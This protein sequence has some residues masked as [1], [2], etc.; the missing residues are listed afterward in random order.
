MNIVFY[1]NIYTATFFI[2]NTSLSKSYF[3]KEIIFQIVFKRAFQEHL[4]FWIVT[5]KEQLIL[6]WSLDISLNTV[7]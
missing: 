7:V 2:Y 1:Y 5:N 4:L 3:H 6:I